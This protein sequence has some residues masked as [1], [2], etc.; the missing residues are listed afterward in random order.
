MHPSS[1]LSY[2]PTYA[3]LDEIV[4]HGNYKT[5]NIFIDLK[6]TLQTTY[7]EHAIVNIVESTKKAS[8]VDTSIFSSLISFLSF[9]KMYGVKRG[10]DLNFIIFFES[11]QSYYHKNISKSYK[12]SRRIDD[13]Y[14]L[15][16]ADRDLFYQVLQANFQLIEKAGNKLPNITVVRMPNLE[17]DF[18]PYYAL[19]R[20]LVQKG[21]GVGNVIYSNDHDLCQCLQDDVFI[22]SKSAKTKKI[23]KSGN[24]ISAVFKKEN[25]I[26]DEYLPLAMAVIGD[27][28]D[29]VTGVKGIG[30]SGFINIFQELVH[31]TGNLEQIYNKV[32]SNE[33]LFNFIPKSIINKK[34]EVVVNDET[35]NKTIS[36]NLR[37]VSFELI[38][39]TLDD[40][41]S[42]EMR[43]KRLIIEKHFSDEKTVSPLETMK[44][45]LEM[46]GVFL[47]ESSIDFLYI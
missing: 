29:D 46:G 34:L 9:H 45:A 26:P 44:K 37:L 38:S 21:N 25:D 14:G 39:R 15:D 36:N 40:P 8:H 42:T 7:M 27:P 30:P 3:I 20:N 13:L 43:D 18:V 23:L 31:M 6:N 5:L 4:S 2:Y 24:V 33:S 28:G 10:I 22:F 16:K 32:H 35:K 11:G 41:P 17:A 19:T 12:V 1:L 47:E